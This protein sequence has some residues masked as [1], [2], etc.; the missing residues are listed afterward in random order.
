[1]IET[2]RNTPAKLV[3]FIFSS[4][5]TTV[6]TW[7]Q[8]SDRE[9]NFAPQ[10]ILETVPEPATGCM[11]IAAALGLAMVRSRKSHLVA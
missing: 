10:L 11:A 9:H 6:G 1:M 7:H 2:Q 8:W 4:Q 5:S 3:G